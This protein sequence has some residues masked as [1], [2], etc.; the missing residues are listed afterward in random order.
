MT[1]QDSEECESQPGS[2]PPLPSYQ[3]TEG[4]FFLI[5]FLNTE[6]ELLAVIQKALFLCVAREHVDTFSLVIL[7]F[8]QEKKNSK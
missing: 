1:E 6:K 4:T 8:L 7:L 2:F 3:Q 5:I